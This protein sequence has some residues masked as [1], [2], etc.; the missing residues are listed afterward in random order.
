MIGFRAQTEAALHRPA[1]GTGYDHEVTDPA[2]IRSERLELPL[3]SR[4]QL[5]RLTQGD[6][7][8]VAR[9]IEAELP[10]EWLEEHR[11]LI[12][13]RLRQ[14]AAH[15][16]DA[17][18]LLRP[19]IATDGP[20]RRVVGGINFHGAPD[21]RGM[22]EVGYGLLPAERGRGYA[23]EA[24]QAMFEWARREHGI[25]RF[26]ASVA[27]DNERSLHLIGK[28]GFRRV[29]EQWDPEDGLELVFELDG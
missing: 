27:P 1:P 29:G 11:A 14:L 15:P 2:P 17:P 28:L 4:S 25:R 20:G 16:E 23:I 22:P 19:I 18:W 6:A 8:S 13:L 24:V 26:R 9:E 10:E 7:A 5:E 3:L 12:A 21:E